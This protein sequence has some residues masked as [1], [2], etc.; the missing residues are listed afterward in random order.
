MKNLIL[1]FTLFGVLTTSAQTN[2]TIQKDSTVTFN[3]SGVCSMCKMRIEEAAKGRG[4]VSGIWDEDSK[5]FSLTYNTALTNPEKVQERIA[6][7]GH[8]TELKIAKEKVYKELPEC[9][10]YRDGAEREIV[11]NQIVGM[12]MEI[13][14]KGNLKPLANA[15]IT[16]FGKETVAT[17]GDNGIFKLNTKSEIETIEIS[18]V[19][20][21]PQLLN[22]QSGQ[23]VT[24]VLNEAKQLQEVKIMSKQR[25]SFISSASII[26]T[27]MITEKELFKAACCNLSESFETNPSVDVSYGDAV[28]GSRQIQMLG[29][30]G[31]YSQLTMENL[32]GPRGLATPWGLNYI[33]GTWV[34]SIQLTKG[35][36][37][38]VN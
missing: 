13:D 23:H 7:V 8:D 22:L 19:G 15:N 2:K 38:V 30:S 16:I 20:Y 36:G 11:D 21:K 4:V 3:V 28:T 18:Y 29:L 35:V 24:I 10:L 31:N 6:Y 27:E 17:T 33:P 1:I 14:A 25:S 37:S 5:V 26:R 34:E 9:C 12:V 32:P